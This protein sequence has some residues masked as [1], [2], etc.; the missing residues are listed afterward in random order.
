M[1]EM[2]GG[3]RG[4]IQRGVLHR[5]DDSGGIQVVDVETAEGVL[6]SAAEV[7][8]SPGLACNPG[9]AGVMALVLAPGGDQ[10]IPLVILAATAAGLGNL[11][12]GEVAIYALDGSARVH[13]KPG[14]EVHV[15]AAQKVVV[16]TVEAQV[17]A[18]SKATVAAPQIELQG[19]VNVVG[20]LRVN[21]TVLNVP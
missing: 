14:G 8:Q 2:V 12:P 10:G 20:V 16:Q 17:T 1:D 15:L 7:L 11:A 4:L 5:V 19:N 21:G 6:R 13:A 18:T 9:T 3:L